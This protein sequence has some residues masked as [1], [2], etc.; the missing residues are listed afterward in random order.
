M[1]SPAATLRQAVSSL[2]F[3][4][5]RIP[6]DHASASILG[7]E[8]AGSG[9]A[10]G[11]DRILTALYVVL[12]AEHVEVTTIDGRSRAVERVTADHES[13]LGLLHLAGPPL[14]H[15][16][17]RRES[18]AAGLPVFALGAAGPGE[19]KGASG[20]VSHVGPFE[21]FWEYML[22][23]AIM[24]T[25]PN[26][27]LGGTGLFDAKG[28]LAAIVTLGLSAVGRWS[29]AIPVDLYFDRRE[30]IEDPRVRETRA[31][32]G[33]YPAA[34]DGGVFVTGVVP[35]GPAH[36]AGLMRGDLILT[37]E[38]QPVSNLR[39]LY[40]E[41]WRRRPGQSIRLQVLR[42]SGL[43]VVSIT[44]RDRYDFFG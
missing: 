34:Q 39:E 8:R 43:R 41:L 10:V 26:P 9:V 12:G 4:Q 18:V 38:G 31:W 22:D 7:D 1:D 35:R 36:D 27:A 32:I 44:A 20:H 5:A 13:G 17:R 24:T 2:A 21:A 23:R 33:V 40:D 6:A 37:V 29:L 16:T 30:W 3:L 28:R 11:P 42:D 14:D 25:I 15:A 19:W